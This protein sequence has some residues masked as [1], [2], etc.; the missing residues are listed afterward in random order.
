VPGWPVPGSWPGPATSRH[1]F[2][3]LFLLPA[4]LTGFLIRLLLQLLARLPAAPFGQLFRPAGL[5]L[6]LIR[7]HVLLEVSIKDI[8]PLWPNVPLPDTPNRRLLHLVSASN[9][10]RVPSFATTNNS[11]RVFRGQNRGEVAHTG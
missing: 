5:L 9:S 1:F 3:Q 6:T 7:H 10:P 8:A 2:I 11:I 4:G